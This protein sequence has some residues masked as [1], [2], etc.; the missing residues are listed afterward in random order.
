MRMVGPNCLGVLNTDAAV[1]M[2][3]TFAPVMPPSGQIGFVSQSG[4]LGLSVPDYA[5]EKG[6]GIAQFVSVGNKAD[7]SGND[8]LLEWENDERISCILMY[9]ENVGNPR[10]FLEIAARVTARKPIIALKSGRS[11]V[12]ARAAQSHTGALAASDLI[13]QGLLEQS[14]VRASSM[15]ELFHMAVAFN[16]RTLPASRRVA[17][18]T[19]L[20]GTGIL[21]ADALESYGF[22]LPELSPDTIQALTPVLAEEAALRNPLDMIASAKPQAYRSALEILLRRRTSIR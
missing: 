5:Q 11:Q 18:L 2:N 7:V 8:L 14:G 10:R 16:A 15:D 6:I 21:A 9:V 12:G 19:N 17:G 3:A 20:G 4:A 1:S 22:E 13:V